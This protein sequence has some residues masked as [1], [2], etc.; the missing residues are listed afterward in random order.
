MLLTKKK[1]IAK[2]K[3]CFKVEKNYTYKIEA[4]KHPIS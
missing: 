3:C 4:E 1:E 2:K